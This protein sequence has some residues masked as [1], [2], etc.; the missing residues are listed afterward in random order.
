MNR[1]FFR[2]VVCAC[3]LWV[4]SGAAA[5]QTAGYKTIEFETTQVTAPDVAVTPDGQHLIFTVLGKLFRMPVAD[6]MAEQLTFGPYFDTDIAISPDG[7]SVVFSSDR[8]GGEGNLFV[9]DLATSGIRQITNE[10]RAIRPNWSPDGKSI[11]YLNIAEQTEPG[12]GPVAPAE[13]KQVAADGSDSKVVRSRGLFTS[14]AYFH[15]GRLAWTRLERGA[16]RFHGSIEV[17]KTEP[18]VEVIKKFE[19]PIYGLVSS[20][21]A[22]FVRANSAD[23]SIGEI[24]VVNTS[25]PP[26]RLVNASSEPRSFALSPDGNSLYMGNM[27][28]L[29]K[30][31]LPGG[32]MSVIPLKIRIRLEVRPM[33]GP[34]NWRPPEPGRD[35][36]L[37]TFL[38]PTLLPDGKGVVFSAMEDYWIQPDEHTPARQITKGL[39]VEPGAALSP[40][41]KEL[42]YL[43]YEKGENARIEVVDIATGKTRVVAPPIKCDYEQLSWSAHGDLIVAT[44]CDHD[45]LA[46]DSATGA[47][48]VIAKKLSSWEPGPH[49]SADGKTLFLQAQM[50]A[51]KPS[52]YKLGLD[53]DAKPEVVRPATTNGGAAKIAG[54]WIAEPVRNSTGIRLMN[55]ADPK[56]DFVIAEADGTEFGLSADGKNVVYSAGDRVWIQ[57]L[58]GS[59]RKEFPIRLTRTVPTPQ[60][61]LIER[62]RVL[63]FETGMFGPETSVFLS[64]GSIEQIGNVRR[65]SLPKTTVVV[66]AAGRYAIPGLF[67]MHGHRNTCG[68]ASEI[69]LGITSTRNMGGRLERLNAFSDASQLTGQPLPRCFQPG[70]ILEGADGR[71]EDFYFVHPKD[72]DDARRYIGRA[73]EQGVDFIKLYERLPWKLQ[74]AASDE[75]H[76]LGLPVVGHSGTVERSFKGLTLGFAGL[77]HALPYYEDIQL[78]VLKTGAH[79]DPTVGTGSGRGVRFRE[80]PVRFKAWPNPIPNM[81]DLAIQGRHYERLKSVRSAH[82]LGIPIVP[83]TDAFTGGIALHW[84]LE[85]F[86]EAGIPRIDVIRSATIVSAKVLGADKHL[87]SIE[88]GKLADLVLL[89]ADPLVDIRNTQK[90]WRTF[91]GG[92]MFD[93]KKLTPNRS[94]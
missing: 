79:W 19:H 12:E 6:G 93:A 76:R 21:N 17:L 1:S 86:E 33:T 67:E 31:A 14:V 77:T 28:N 59:P 52:F 22:A 8:D 39:S 75:A 51:G 91:K 62:V 30:I 55:I 16:V 7:K 50:E 32:G 71:S 85:F 46:I 26:R 37:R 3:I 34:R 68:G 49:L 64:G 70:R 87:G 80:D 53:N 72:E 9:L 66:D 89:D 57:P 74:R 73:H 60:P 81:G 69:S 78:M 40:T 29:W 18:D 61:V 90:V 65:S 38:S 5:S 15:D 10:Y 27:G 44:S 84:E 92:W 25:G 45:I 41:G 23:L 82:R 2:V 43:I 54:D 83:G 35:G 13:I 88:V 42:A 48:K 94:P 36:R 20:K 11:V 47:S 4:F 24:T 56:R 58:D 63:N